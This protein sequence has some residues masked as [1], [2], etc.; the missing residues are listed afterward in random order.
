[1]PAIQVILNDESQIYPLEEGKPVFIGRAKECDIHLPSSSVS[2]RH[3]VILC[4]D[5][6]CG[7]KDLN[8]F[9]GTTLN[10][11]PV[12]IPQQLTPKDVLRISSFVI[13]LLPDTVAQADASAKPKSPRASARM[14]PN[15]EL[16][17]PRAMEPEEA[18]ERLIEEIQ[19]NTV[20]TSDG[21]DETHEYDPGSDTS[22][23]PRASDGK[24]TLD[25][26]PTTDVS[27][28]AP[29]QPPVESEPPSGLPDSEFD[30]S[31]ESEYKPDASRPAE[32]GNETGTLENAEDILV[33]SA[34]TSAEAEAV[35]PMNDPDTEETLT[36]SGDEEEDG[37]GNAVEGKAQDGGLEAQHKAGETAFVEE[38]EGA[39]VVGTGEDAEEVAVDEEV[40]E[41]HDIF[42]ADQAT[43]SE[44]IESEPRTSESGRILITTGKLNIL[45]R[46]QGEKNGVPGLD[47]VPVSP[48]LS[49]AINSRLSI[50]FLLFDLAEERKLFRMGNKNLSAAVEAEL[51]RQDAEL[52]NLPSSEAAE[53]NIRQL[54]EAHAALDA[55]E[56]DGESGEGGSGGPLMRA[57]EEMAH[58]QWLI[59]R[60]CNRQALPAIYKE[61]YRL[62]ADEPL[63][64]ELSAARISHGRLL[65]GAIYLLV[66]E[67]MCHAADAERRR[68]NGDIRKLSGE[69]PDKGRDG[70]LGTFGKLGRLAGNLMNRNEIKAETARLEELERDTS[71]QAELAAKEMNFLEKA[72]I[73]EYRQVYK[74]TAM[75][76]IPRNEAIPLAVRAFLRYGVIGFK[77]WWM[78]SDA[79]ELILRDC[80]DNVISSFE[81]GSG[82]T[83][84]LYADEYLAAVAGMECSP[85]PD[86]R[87]AAVD[88]ASMEWK[89]DRAFRRIVNSRTYCV[90]MEETIK[91]IG[92]RIRVLEDEMRALDGRIAGHNSVSAAGKEM[93]LE[94]QTG[95][96]AVSIR[97]ENLEKYARR[98][99]KEV[100]P[101]ILEAV[102]EAEG[103]FRKGEL[104]LPNQQT[105]IRREVNALA[106]VS[107]LM[108]GQRE[109]FM[110]MAIRG[111]YLSDGDAINERALVRAQ[112]DRLEQ[113]D[114]GIFRITI[115]PAKKRANRVE[116]RLSP[117]VIVIPASG[118]HGVCTMGREGMEG[119]HLVLPSCFAKQDLRDR[120]FGN[121]LADFRWVT[122]RSMGGRDVMN[123]D[124]LVGAFMRIR[125]EWRNYPKQKRE[126]GL[127]FNENSDAVNWRRVYECYLA[128]AMKGGR[129]LH[130]RNP[131]CYFG[132]IG[133]YIDLPEGVKLLPR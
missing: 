16:L 35:I 126:K 109:R 75:H 7:V 60:D 84:I 88:R 103:R 6:V 42:E 78:R 39:E 40:P 12:T 11:L 37:A 113:L 53:E 21:V 22:F 90:L 114:P 110:P 124:T 67:G 68:I 91:G 38:A 66:L 97:K 107:R 54:K 14:Y 127:I 34:L 87:L 9:N 99:E 81:R 133:K 62:A 48:A 33:E 80:S 125:W 55:N 26:G 131:D 56:Q 132:I 41:S 85:S 43:N 96:Q 70:L 116:L 32:Q 27:A 121:L 117:M 129:L 50:Y 73:R 2:R 112:F 119:G 101:S 94:L 74:K 59:I 30:E 115:V 77:G 123:S 15:S 1:M 58:S 128:D 25:G 51:A 105:L 20:R 95:S 122:S 28:P 76:F 89:A 63:A 83:N 36:L 86:E 24:G 98:I 57:A 44:E 46:V 17:I 47:A 93:L 64:R 5:G 106:E 69:A 23:F 4:K 8:S 111:L 10:D 19:P 52:D 102:A 104:P 130:S 45:D 79:R 92:E 65:G 118:Y 61:A 82:E 31:E 29:S 120:Q 18:L 49:A 13:R 100:V 108:A 72:L 71:L 3:A